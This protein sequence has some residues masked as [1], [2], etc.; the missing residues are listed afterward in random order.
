MAAD[1]FEELEL[2]FGYEDYIEITEVFPNVLR[3]SAFVFVLTLF[4]SELNEACE[5]IQEE[6]CAR[7]SV[8]DI[9]GQ[10]L[11]RAATY[12]H[13]LTD[14]RVTQLP[15]WSELMNLYAVRNV[16]VHS[17][18]RIGKNKLD[19][20]VTAVAKTNPYID[21]QPADMESPAGDQVIQVKSG[22]TEYT[23]GLVRGMWERL[24]TALA[25]IPTDSVA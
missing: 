20:S 2:E 9:R 13:K 24:V 10:G 3:R 1:S 4:E 21:L 16:L 7:F 8:Y 5:K 19:S 17:N 18:G 22:L 23:V 25:E 11:Q 12:I 6:F 15:E 14:V